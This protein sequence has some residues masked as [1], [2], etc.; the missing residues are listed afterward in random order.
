MSER[1][2]DRRAELRHL[3]NELRGEVRSYY[4]GDMEGEGFASRLRSIASELDRHADAIAARDEQPDTEENPVEETETVA[5]LV[6]GQRVH[7][8]ES[9]DTQMVVLRIRALT[10]AR[11]HQIDAID[12]TVA[13]ANPNYPP[14][15]PVVDVAFVS[16]IEDT[17]G[18][19]WEADD[20]VE[21]FQD[22]QLR[23]ARINHYAYPVSRLGAVE[24]GE[25]Q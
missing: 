6:H 16:G 15:D 1:E 23:R 17:L 18:I 25:S 8:R 21:L 14:S 19:D 11:E 12:Q 24:D 2:H 22:D 4:D 20:V 5:E 7:D 13:E 3:P 9:D 10:S